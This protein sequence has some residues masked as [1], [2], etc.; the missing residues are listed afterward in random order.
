MYDWPD[1][2]LLVVFVALI[3]RP[4]WRLTL[5]ARA[6]FGEMADAGSRMPHRHSGDGDGRT[7]AHGVYKETEINKSCA[8]YF[9][10]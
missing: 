7:S 1:Q 8:F 2:K 3:A 4:E 5:V 6:L 10:F 9:F